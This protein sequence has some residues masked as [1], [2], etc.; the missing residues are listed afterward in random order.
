MELLSPAG[1]FDSLK[2]AVQNGADAVYIGAQN[3]SARNLADNFSD[4]AS[5][6]SY[7]HE[8]GV[9]LYLALNTLVR[10][11]E[12]KEWLH[13][14]Q[15][16]AQAGV[17]AFILQDLGCAMLLKNLCPSISLHASTQMTA[18][19]ASH[20]RML[21]ELGFERIILSRELS[22]SDIC[23]IR[24]ATGAQLEIFVHGAL[25]VCYSGQCLMSSIF[26][27]RS[28]NRGLCAQPCRLNYMAG[29]KK[30]RLLSTRDL[31]LIDYVSQIKEA[32]IASIKIEG[33]MKPAAYVGTVTRIYRKALDG[34]TITQ[35]DKDDL[36]KAYSRRGFTDKPFALAAQQAH[37]PAPAHNPAC[38]SP[39]NQDC[40]FEDYRPL[41]KG[42]RKKPRKLAAQVVTFD[43]AK[44][45]LP[46]VDILY[47]PID[48]EWIKKLRDI[49]QDNAP[50]LIGTHPLIAHEGEAPAYD[51]ALFDGEMFGT[52]V[53]SSAAHKISDASIHVMNSE[54]LKTLK[55]LGF[56][57][58]TISP[59]L[60]AAQIADLSDVMPTEV[61]AYGRLTLMTTMHCPLRCNQRSCSV[62]Q[63]KAFLTDRMKKRFPLYKAGSGCNV[64]ILNSAPIY[65]ADQP[66]K[67]SATVI[68][69]VFTIESPQECK[70]IAME[71][72]DSLKGLPQKPPQN[73]TR[74]HFTRG[75]K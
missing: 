27:G 15:Q 75:V 12:I 35:Q 8:A 24:E 19:N 32:G 44:S 20:V 68:R 54:T 40:R 36:L 73:F 69:L 74:G 1:G 72:R 34:Q 13:T 67:L 39:A 59:E 51:G 5:A 43:Q 49:R 61:I 42:K 29:E 62:A 31:C 41:T 45:I 2:A 57:R 46:L 28:A 25:C 37:I 53:A 64:G 70:K 9:K 48:A 10:D 30:G 16:A 56:E 50:R 23:K 21:Q 63:G 17:D 71:Y 6:V 38:V 60:N 26:G 47:V 7:A 52:L 65:M 22:F 66:E 33:R 4:L 55:S 18:H 3:F 11:R 14:A 58:A